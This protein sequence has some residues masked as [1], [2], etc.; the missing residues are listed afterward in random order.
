[1]SYV[2]PIPTSK[3]GH[4]APFH[5]TKMPHTNSTEQH[6]LRPILLPE[7][8]RVKCVQ[9]TWPHEH[10]D[11]A[12]MLEEVTACYLQLAYAIATRT[13][14]LIVTPA[15]E[16][17][18]SLLKI[19]LP[20]SALQNITI[21]P[22]PT[23][24]T[25]ARDHGAITCQSPDGHLQLL[26]FRFNGWGG[27]FE[28]SLDNK[29][30]RALFDAGILTG[31]YINHLDFELEG[32]SIESDGEGTLLTTSECL[33]NPNRNP[34]LSKEIIEQRLKLWFGLDR[35]L[36]LDHGYLAGDDT[37]S[38]IDT[39][40]RLCPNDTIAYVQCTDPNDEH[41]DALH[42]MEQQLQTFT[43]KHGAPYTLIPLPMAAP[44]Y[45]EDGERL[46]ATYA[47]Y[48]VVNT[49]VLYPTYAN[50]ELDQ[51][52]HAQLAKAFPGYELVGIDCTALIRQ[53]G[54]LH[55][56]TMQLYDVRSEEGV[57]RRE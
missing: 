6:P 7:W 26:D 24:D 45:D 55:C 1:M 34:E 42:A 5:H 9:L 22:C 14:L 33:L 49:S 2:V 25:W 3:G 36:W 16:Q 38:H 46:P 21:F 10:T 13:K 27:K 50:P 23:N 51:M 54:S 19:K 41:Y 11:W 4:I 30:T 12:C 57:V 53:H 44:A 20:A 15:P 35:I 31:A 56:A 29:I 47:N 17:V 48:L 28:A 8:G 37:D 40:A 18:E 52:A 39:L 43:T 32:G